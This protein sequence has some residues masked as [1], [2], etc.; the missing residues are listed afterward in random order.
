MHAE[1][2]K[3]FA[4]IVEL[5]GENVIV[6]VLPFL[7]EQA[8]G[9]GDQCVEIR[10]VLLLGLVV[11]APGLGQARCVCE[12]VRCLMQQGFAPR[13]LHGGRHGAHIVALI[14]VRREGHL[15]ATQFEV[16]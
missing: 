4:A 8:F 15:L 11:A 10:F 16:A 13:L 5:F 1:F 12:Y 6:Y 3:V 9:I 2:G 14:G 7:A